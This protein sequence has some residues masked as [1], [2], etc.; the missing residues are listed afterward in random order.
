MAKLN[1]EMTMAALITKLARGTKALEANELAEFSSSTAH[2]VTVAN[3]RASQL[4]SSG[5]HTFRNYA[6]AKNSGPS[7]RDELKGIHTKTDVHVLIEEADEAGSSSSAT[8]PH[9]GDSRHS[10]P[11]QKPSLGKT[12]EDEMPLRE[13]VPAPAKSWK[14][15]RR[16]EDLV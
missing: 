16:D 3:G 11:I 5:S 2:H 8:E 6:A 4:Q 14:G 9:P 1:I 15:G 13:Q 7:N 12:E 10:L